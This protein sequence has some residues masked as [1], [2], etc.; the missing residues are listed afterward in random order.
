M[1]DSNNLLVNIQHL[2]KSIARMMVYWV[3]NS[4]HDL[5]EDLLANKPDGVWNE[6]EF[7]EVFKDL[8]NE[9]DN[10]AE[11]KEF[12]AKASNLFNE[13]D[14]RKGAERINQRV[15]GKDGE[16]P[17]WCKTLDPDCPS[18]QTLN[19][20][21]NCAMSYIDNTDWQMITSATQLGQG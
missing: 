19:V 12:F 20:M 6:L 16:D 3:V 17:D 2:K 8:N 11:W 10:Y 9:T 14:V 1:C 18:N 21:F 7:K 13:P 4:R 15:D 5:R